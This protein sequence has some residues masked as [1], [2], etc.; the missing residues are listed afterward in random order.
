MQI[1]GELLGVAGHGWDYVLPGLD[2][3]N[4]E[5]ITQR[6][7]VSAQLVVLR[8]EYSYHSTADLITGFWPIN[9]NL[10]NC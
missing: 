2:V 8:P 7:Y 5:G 10:I 9:E 4:V 6:L 1:D 3:R